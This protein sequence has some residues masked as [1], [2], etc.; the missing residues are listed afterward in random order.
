MEVMNVNIDW[1]TFRAILKRSDLKMQTPTF[2]QVAAMGEEIKAS[3]TIVH[4]SWKRTADNVSEWGVDLTK[5]ELQACVQRLQN[6][7]LPV[8]VEFQDALARFPSY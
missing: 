4:F 6:E 3:P 1:A 5:D 2:G 7:N 8:P